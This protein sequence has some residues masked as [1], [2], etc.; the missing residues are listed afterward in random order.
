MHRLLNLLTDVSSRLS[1]APLFW[2][3]AFFVPFFFLFWLRRDQ[4]RLPGCIANWIAVGSAC[5]V[6]A[7]FIAADAF[8]CLSSAFWDHNEPGVGIQSWLF[9]R[10]DAV[11]QNLVT[12][13]RYSGPYGPYGYIAVGLCQG[14]IGPG[15]FATKLWPCIAGA[16]AI[17][18]FYIF[19]RRRSSVR[20]ALIFTSLLAALSL[21]L[22]PFAFWTR[23]EP[24]LVLC[25]TAGLIAATRK[26]LVSTVLLGVSLGIAID[27][28]INS[29]CYFFPVVVLAVETGFAW[30]ELAK[31]VAIAAVVVILP[32][33]VFPQVSLSNYVGILQLI[34]K[35]GFGFLEFHL[36]LEWLVTLLVP[37]GAGPLFCR[38]TPSERHGETAGNRK[39]FLAAIV[40]AS[41]A[42]LLSASRLGA[43]PHHFLPLIPIV[44]FFAAEQTAKGRSVQWPSG[45]MAVTGYALCFSWLLSCVLVALGSAYSISA[46]AIRQESE[47]AASIR[48]LEQLLNEHPAYTWLGG[49]SLNGVPVESSYHL[50]LVFK[51]MPPGLHPPAQMDF[52]L[53]ENPETNLTKLELEI[54]GRYRRPVAWVVP[55]GSLPFGMKTA[56]DQSRPL[57]SE[58]FQ[59]EF[60]ER[61]VKAGSSRFFDFYLPR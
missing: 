56:F 4:P 42:L 57:F 35:R 1:W 55:K 18:L 13:Q 23:P 26:G 27:L 60:A 47:A 22:G 51:G 46:A 10:N 11:Y 2:P 33:L 38:Q 19:L 7:A 54:R 44:L 40:V 43:G 6:L 17:G 45:M 58:K 15:V 20:L 21:R 41:L 24:F 50:Q 29:I 30:R 16:V 31:A 34:G 37:V 39:W 59:R 9:W 48:D 8:Y 32:F 5:L 28:K 12:Q 25:V 14:L 61:F 49:A 36:S 52:Q 53:A 3:F